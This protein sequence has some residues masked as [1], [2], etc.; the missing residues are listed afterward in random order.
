M[1][2]LMFYHLCDAVTF[3]PVIFKKENDPL[4]KDI[5]IYL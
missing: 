5:Y 4:K 1:M 3:Y 2:H